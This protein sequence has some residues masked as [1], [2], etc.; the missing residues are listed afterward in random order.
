MYCF[1]TH[2]QN[3]FRYSCNSAKMNLERKIVLILTHQWEKMG[4]DG[5]DM[6]DDTLLILL[7]KRPKTIAETRMVQT[8]IKKV[9]DR[10]NKRSYGMVYCYFKQNPKY[11]QH[12]I[13]SRKH[14]IVIFTFYNGFI[15]GLT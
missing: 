3:I 12:P 2:H 14:Y 15:C 5:G 6:F 13:E 7:K 9:G 1:Q 10:K 8:T 11:A 4:E